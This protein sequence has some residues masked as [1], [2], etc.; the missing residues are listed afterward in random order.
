MPH[1]RIEE[2]QTSFSEIFNYFL[3]LPNH[4]LNDLVT[5]GGVTFSARA[6]TTLDGRRFIEL[7]HNN[8]IYE[9]DWGYRYNSMGHGGQRIGHYSIPINKAYLG[10]DLDL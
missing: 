5:T 3:S 6:S 9:A 8:R 7:P 1:G 10:R 2:I 4:N